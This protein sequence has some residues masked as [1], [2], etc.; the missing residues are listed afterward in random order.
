M[1]NTSSVLT[2]ERLK[3]LLHYDADT[4]VFTWLK[5]RSN[6][7]AGSLA[8]A[9]R[10]N[11]YIQICLDRKFWLAHRLAWL[12]MTGQMPDDQVDHIDGN[13]INNSW[14]NLRPSTTKQNAEN[15]KQLKNNSS[16]FRGVVYYKRTNR[17]MAQLQHNGKNMCLGYFLTA[18]QAADVARAKRAELFTHDHGRAA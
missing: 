11:G 13:G 2:Q 10:K 7:K 5:N 12:Y 6:V 4:G 16:G 3:E 14:L 9:L 15:L 18:E 1:P 8:G 17:W